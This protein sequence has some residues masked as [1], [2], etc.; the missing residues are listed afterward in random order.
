MSVMRPGQRHLNELEIALIERIALE[1]PNDHL[2][3]GNLQV[4]QRTYTCVGSFTDFLVKDRPKTA[5]R[6]VI[7]TKAC[8]I[9][10]GLQRGLGVVAFLEGNTLMLELCAFGDEYWDGLFEGFTLVPP[11]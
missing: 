6:R 4:L 10:P 2:S 8:V 11:T 3:V 1:N 7:G 5:E 9:I